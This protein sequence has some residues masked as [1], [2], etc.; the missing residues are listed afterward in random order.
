M[1]FGDT[2]SLSFHFVLSSVLS[3][4]RP[5]IPSGRSRHASLDM[6]NKRSILWA[7]RTFPRLP[8]NAARDSTDRCIPCP[9]ISRRPSRAGR[10]CAPTAPGSAARRRAAGRPADAADQARPARSPMILSRPGGRG[11]S[12]GAGRWSAHRPA[13]DGRGVVRPG[14]RPERAAGPRSSRGRRRAPTSWAPACR[15]W[16]MRPGPAPT[17]DDCSASSGGYAAVYDTILPCSTTTSTDTRKP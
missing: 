15:R 6:S 12:T 5:L 9:C 3:V 7:W 11:P 4:E 2:S 13:R 16:P 14:A 8:V 10:R 1:I 17:S